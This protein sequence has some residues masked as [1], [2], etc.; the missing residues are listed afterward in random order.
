MHPRRS[1]ISGTDFAVV[2]SAMCPNDLQSE[3]LDYELLLRKVIVA[4]DASRQKRASLLKQILRD[5]ADGENFELHYDIDPEIDLEICKKNYREI[6][7]MVT[8]LPRSQTSHLKARLLHLGH[9]LAVI[10]NHAI[11]EIRFESDLVFRKVLDLLNESFW[12]ENAFLDKEHEAEQFDNHRFTFAEKRRTGAIPKRVVEPEFVTKEV[13]DRAMKDVGSLIQALA[14]QNSSMREEINKLTTI[15]TTQFHASASNNPTSLPVQTEM[16]PC[17]RSNP[18]LNKTNPF[19]LPEEEI[20]PCAAPYFTNRD[21]NPF[22]EENPAMSDV[23][24]HEPPENPNYNISPIQLTSVQPPPFEPNPR[25]FPSSLNYSRRK[26][27]PVSQWKIKK[28]SGNDQDPGLGT[29]KSSNFQRI[30]ANYVPPGEGECYNCGDLHDLEA[31]PIP[32]LTIYDIPIQALLDSG[33]SLT[34][35]NSRVFDRLNRVKI[36]PLSD[37]VEL[38]TADGSNL[39]VIGEVL[40][41]FRYNNKTR[42][43]KTLVAPS[44]TK[45]CICGIDFWE[46]FGIYPAIATISKSPVKQLT[47]SEKPRLSLEQLASLEEVKRSFKTADSDYLDTTDLCEHHIVI[48]DEFKSAKPIRLYPYPLAPKIQEGLFAEIDRLLAR[49]IIE[50]S[51]SDWSL[52]VVPIRKPSGE[53]RLCLDARKLNERTVRDAYP[54]PHP[55]RILSRL[56]RAKFL[57]TIDLTEA[58]LQ[59]PLARE[60]RKYCAFSVQGRGMFAFRR[61]PYGLL[62]SPASLARLMSRVLGNGELEPNVFVY[63]DDIVLVT[64]TFEDHIRLLSEISKRLRRANLSIKLEKSHFCLEEI[65][66][67]GYILS[68]RGLQV[69]PEKIRPIV[70]YERPVTVTKLRRFLG[71]SNYYRRFIAD[72]SKITAPLSELLKTK[73]KTIKWTSEAEVAFQVIKEKLITSPILASADFDHEFI[74]HT[75][76]SNHAV[77]GVLTQRLADQEHVIEYFSKKLT[78]PER[79]YHATEKEGLAA[80]LSIEHFRGYIEGSHF[81]LVTD[82]SALTFIM[83]SKW[84]TSSRLSRWSL[85]LQQYDM[86]IVHRRGRDN[87]VPDALS[88]SVMAIQSTSKSS[89]YN[90]LKSKVDTNPEDY[91]DF[92]LD[93][94][95]LLKYVFQDDLTDHRFDWKIVVPEDHKQDILTAA[96]DQFMHQGAEKT[97][98]K[99]RQ[100]YYWPGMTK[101]VKSFIKKCQVCKEIKPP[102]TATTPLMGDMRTP[103]RPWEIIALD[104]IGPLPRSKSGKQYILV[105]LDLFSKW[106]QMKAF[107]QISITVPLLPPK[108]SVH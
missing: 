6:H 75:D 45:D 33:S 1:S 3:E 12:S 24:T 73:N 91:P 71:M 107:P 83:R 66:F 49:G 43:I 14:K 61:C 69:N 78:T 79:S 20:P 97:L 68:S 10:K 47:D 67:L 44:L 87:V 55:G 95:N 89:W 77:A 90:D 9:R 32:H 108:S 8:S 56:P 54:L 34:F 22:L 88:R 19:L 51:N 31:C 98:A 62:N 64:E 40:L 25:F 92:R 81:T 17:P 70:E 36:R 93:G 29:R 2:Y 13:F 103:T 52:N 21:S 82:S 57:S 5:E 84:K 99:I 106:V 85:S 18:K 38:R 50:E 72:Y 15:I 100:Q 4:E 35:I 23:V 37:S 63:L 53:I 104:Y 59:I 48:K 80:L 74:L 65:P 27:I 76:A 11:G 86:T 39:E 7:Q 102:N 105:A 28:Y 58:F 101:D 94:D 96:H 46:R 42:I 60:S 16:I 30:V 41:P 26:V